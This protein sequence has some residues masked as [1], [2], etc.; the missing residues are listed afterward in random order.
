MFVSLSAVGIAVEIVYPATLLRFGGFEPDNQFALV[1]LV[2]SSWLYHFCQAGASVLIGATSLLALRMGVLPRWLA[3]AGFVV[4][5]LTLL[6]F[7]FPLLGALAGLLWIAAVA[8][9]MLAGGVRYIGA[10]HTRAVDR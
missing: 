6:H 2:L 3:L 4:A 9:V 10:P 5:L 8:A 1:S 7:L